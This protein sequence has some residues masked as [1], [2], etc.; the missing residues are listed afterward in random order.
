MTMGKGVAMDD[1]PASADG[2]G[3][4]E[5]PYILCFAVTP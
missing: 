2:Q 3:A 1:E 4:Q 5:V